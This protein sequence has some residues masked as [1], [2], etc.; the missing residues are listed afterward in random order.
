MIKRTVFALAALSVLG[1][2]E[3]Q[4]ASRITVN[5][6]RLQFS[7]LVAPKASA[8][9]TQSASQL[10]PA[11]VRAFEQ[12][13]TRYLHRF[14]L[15]PPPATDLLPNTT[16]AFRQQFIRTLFTPGMSVGG[17]FFS[18]SATP[19]VPGRFVNVFQFFPVYRLFGIT[20]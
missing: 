3:A 12:R 1:F 7:A 6:A 4:A 2:S 18:T 16:I 13:L 11:A 20:S 5:K 15:V 17:V 10:N 8:I 14:G 19:T 9:R